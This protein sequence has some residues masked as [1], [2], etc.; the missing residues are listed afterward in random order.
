MGFID[1]ILQEGF[2]KGLEK[3][4]E[5]GI[6]QGMEMGRADGNARSLIQV[7][8]LRFGPLKTDY[9]DRIFKSDLA[10]VEAWLTRAVKASDLQ[11]VFE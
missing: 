3:G 11:T 7:L 5:K 8:E 9:R 2:E 4:M 10:S 1:E 6:E